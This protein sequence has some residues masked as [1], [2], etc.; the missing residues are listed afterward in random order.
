M[1]LEM[2]HSPRPEFQRTLVP[3]RRPPHVAPAIDWK[4]ELVKKARMDGYHLGYRN[5]QTSDETYTTTD[6]YTAWLEGWRQGQRELWAEIQG[7]E[8]IA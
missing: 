4:A 2:N 5:Q 7:R 1:S 8:A 6:E 3:R